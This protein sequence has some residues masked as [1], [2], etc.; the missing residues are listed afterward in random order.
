MLCTEEA[1]TTG[2]LVVGG[3]GFG[4]FCI[5]AFFLFAV[6]FR[7]MAQYARLSALCPAGIRAFV[8]SYRKRH[9]GHIHN[10]YT[11]LH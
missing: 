2:A 8:P 3:L 7:Q 4:G 10:F 1:N 11:N 9:A 5:G 6:L